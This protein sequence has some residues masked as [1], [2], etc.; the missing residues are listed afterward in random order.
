MASHQSADFN[1]NF[2]S[3]ALYTLNRN[4]AYTR[5]AACTTDPQASFCLRIKIDKSSSFQNTAVQ[6]YRTKKTNL[7]V[8]RKKYFKWRMR[9][10]CTVKKSK[11]IGNC[12]TVIATKCSSV[13]CYVA[14]FYRNVQSILCKIM[15]YIR[16]FLAYHIHMS[17][18]DNSRGFL[19]SWC[20]RLVDDHIVHLIL[21]IF[22]SMILCKFHKVITD[23]F[24]ITGTMRDFADFLKIIKNSLRFTIL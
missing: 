9:N 3:L 22:E 10:I 16:T 17:L 24:R 8:N 11:A 18:D 13:G 14:V 20:A 19:I 6:S 23:L 15:I 4:M 2:V 21:H 12:N 5:K 1:L 7:L